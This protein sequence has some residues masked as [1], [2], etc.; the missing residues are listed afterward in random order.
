MPWDD[1]D[2][3]RGWLTSTTLLE[4]AKA[5]GELSATRRVY[6]EYFRRGANG[7]LDLAELMDLLPDVFSAVGYSAEE[8]GKVIAML[9]ALTL[10][11]VGVDLDE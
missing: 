8:G 2:N 3:V 7:G 4:L 6:I 9:K 1:S 11:D 10:R 5:R